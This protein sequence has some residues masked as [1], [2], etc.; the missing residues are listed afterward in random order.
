MDPTISFNEFT[1]PNPPINYITSNENYDHLNVKSNNNKP[2]IIKVDIS[3]ENISND[4]PG[5]I[6]GENVGTLSTGLINHYLH[7]YPNLHKLIII[8]KHFLYK[9]EFNKSYQGSYNI[10]F[11]YIKL[12]DIGGISSYCMSLMIIAYL[13]E[14]SYKFNQDSPEILADLFHFYGKKFN[15]K[16][17][18]ISIKMKPRYI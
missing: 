5:F 15:P 11:N 10:I 7:V 9:K 13:M 14:N 8:F 3:L 2:I 17:T 6:L 12:Y 4:F 16:E 18:G 1:Y